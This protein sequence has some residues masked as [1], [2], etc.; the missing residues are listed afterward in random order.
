ML[1]TVYIPMVLED[2]K[3]LHQW[4]VQLQYESQETDQQ[5]V[6][7]PFHKHHGVLQLQMVVSHYLQIHFLQKKN[8][9]IKSFL[10]KKKTTTTYLASKKRCS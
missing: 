10:F 9:E 1:Q 8:K 6:R 4:S 7:N 3:R 5:V 2:L